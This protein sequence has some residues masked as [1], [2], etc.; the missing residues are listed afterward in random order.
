MKRLFLAILLM[1]PSA[2]LAYEPPVLEN[3]K[4]CT[5]PT[6]G[7]SCSFGVNEDGIVKFPDAIVTGPVGI[8]GGRNVHVTAGHIRLGRSSRTTMGFNEPQNVFVEGLHLDS[9]G[10]CDIFGIRNKTN[11]PNV[12]FTFQNIYAEGPKYNVVNG[13]CHGDLIQIQDESAVGNL[14]LRVEN[15][16]GVTDAQGLFLPGRWE[17]QHS[18]ELRNVYIRMDNPHGYGLLW[19]SAAHRPTVFI[20][21]PYPVTLENVWVDWNG[22]SEQLYPKTGTVVNGQY[23]WPPEELIT[24]VVNY[25]FDVDE[26]AFKAHVGLTYDPEY[27]GSEPAPDPAPDPVPDLNLANA[28][29][30]LAN[31]ENFDP[32]NPVEGLWD[33]CVDGSSACSPGDG[34]ITSFWVEFD[35][36]QLHDLTQARLFGDATGAW[37]SRLWGLEHKVN[38]GDPWTTAVAADAFANEWLTEDLNIRARYILL[39]VH[40]GAATQAREFELLGTVVPDSDPVPDP[41]PVPV[42]DPD[43]I[44]DPEPD[45]I[46]DPIPEPDPAV[47]PQ[48]FTDWCF[49]THHKH[50]CQ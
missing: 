8:T 23:V 9:S 18:V 38:A 32:N 26:A 50:D 42:P 1:L 5:I 37:V 43:P 31:S 11:N 40:G 35:L 16:V 36:G 21:P 19:F 25:G 45:P 20:D 49:E 15:F 46:P 48:W 22:G 29:T 44:P 24:G 17:G 3:P 2:A 12:S 7:G 13:D 10:Y 30:M 33:K 47:I 34:A 28:S 41:D 14:T 6:S 27:F 39:T 4:V